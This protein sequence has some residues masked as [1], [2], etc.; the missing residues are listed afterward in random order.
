MNAGNNIEIIT[1]CPI[2]GKDSRNL[3]FRLGG[4]FEVRKCRTC[5]LFFRYLSSVPDFLSY[6]SN[7]YKQWDIP[8][9]HRAYEQDKTSDFRSALKRISMYKKG[10]T[11]L[12][13]GC[14]T[15]EFMNIA[16]EFGFRTT[17]IEPQ[18]RA[19]EIAREKYGLNVINKDFLGT[20]W[21]N[22]TPDV[23]TMIHL[24]E[25][26]PDPSE[27]LRKVK[28]ILSPNGIVVIEIPY[29]SLLWTPLLRRHHPIFEGSHLIFF[30]KESIVS[31]LKAEGF[32]ILRLKRVGRTMTI[33][34]LVSRMFFLL[35]IILKEE[36][37]FIR[38]LNGFKLYLNLGFQLEIIAQNSRS[39]CSSG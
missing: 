21:Q 15:G 6:D 29:L 3:S 34:H 11:L 16:R 24:L 32:R 27:V 36:S 19:A 26:L 12:D 13:I 28:R 33:A 10:G 18:K 30:T 39:C 8:E 4:N 5:N 2:C 7:Y 9:S 14:S 31:L 35:N 17:G 22:D 20:K 23:V 25:H 1:R 37:P 38:M